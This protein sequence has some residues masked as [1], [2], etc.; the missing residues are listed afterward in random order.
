MI[1]I[2]CSGSGFRI[3]K[4]DLICQ[5]VSQKLGLGV[6]TLPMNFKCVV[7]YDLPDAAN[8]GFLYFESRLILD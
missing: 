7:I 4:G 3:V 6:Q 5:A 2:L 8:A 1:I